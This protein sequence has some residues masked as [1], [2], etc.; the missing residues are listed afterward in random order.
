MTTLAVNR[1]V[2]SS[3]TRAA[4]GLV[5]LTPCFAGVLRFSRNSSHRGEEL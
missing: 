2:A 4:Y 5:R 3:S 1:C